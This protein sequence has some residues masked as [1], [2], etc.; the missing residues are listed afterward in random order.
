[1]NCPVCAGRDRDRV[2]E[3]AGVDGL[4]TFTMTRCRGCGHLAIF[5]VPEDLARYYDSGYHAHGFVVPPPFAA[6]AG[7]RGAFKRALLSVVYGYEVAPAPG[8]GW[9]ALAPLLRVAAHKFMLFPRP[10]NGRRLLELGCGSGAQL[11]VL[12][13]AGWDVSGVELGASAAR[14]ARERLGLNV[15]QG[16]LE[17]ARLPSASFDVVVASHVLEHIPDPAAASVEIA[18]VLRPGGR[19]YVSVPNGEAVEASWFGRFWDWEAPHHLHHFTPGSLGR[20]LER[21]GLRVESERHEL[22]SSATDVRLALRNS[23]GGAP[24]ALPAFLGALYAPLGFL[25]A[26]SGRGTR[27]CLVCRKA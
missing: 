7:W 12:A 20:M 6:A 5:P 21:A 2:F 1:V 24:A 10:E 16:S 18:R 13:E 4:S 14:Y 23:F 27:F 11:K 9:R 17:S 15:H 8:A 25:L 19:L 26:A 3:V 22:F